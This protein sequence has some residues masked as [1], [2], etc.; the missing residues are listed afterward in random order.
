MP[1]DTVGTVQAWIWWRC[2]QSLCPRSL[3]DLGP[4]SEVLVFKDCSLN[5]CL[6]PELRHQ[7][8]V[9]GEPSTLSLSALFID[10]ICKDWSTM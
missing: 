1:V 8:T 9:S 5:H 7:P 4:K 2:A 3:R 6:L 10:P